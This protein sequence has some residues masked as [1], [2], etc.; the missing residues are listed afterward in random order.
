DLATTLEWNARLPAE[1]A[2]RLRDVRGMANHLTGP[3][4]DEAN[5][6]RRATDT[7]DDH[8]RE[9]LDVDADAAADVEHFA[10]NPGDVAMQQPVEG[11]AVIEHV[12]PVA[13][14]AAVAVNAQRLVPPRAR[15][16][17]APHL[18]PGLATA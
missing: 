6:R 11:L 10:G 7:L 5:Q 13:R 17:A 18:F 1:H 4:G 9:S 8:L 12:D 14:G 16:Q 2:P 3:V 15:H